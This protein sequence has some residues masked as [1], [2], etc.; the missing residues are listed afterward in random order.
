VRIGNLPDVRERLETQGLTVSTNT[1][2]EYA[3]LIRADYTRWGR[4]V[5][6]SGAQIN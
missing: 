4:V 2:E 3:K 1:P 5:D 6:S